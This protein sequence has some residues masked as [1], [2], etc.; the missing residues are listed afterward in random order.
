[1]VCDFLHRKKTINFPMVQ[2]KMVLKFVPN[3]IFYYGPTITIFILKNIGFT[4]RKMRRF[5]H[6]FCVTAIL[7]CSST[8]LFPG[9][10]ETV[11]SF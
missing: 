3:V 2:Q 8:N 1:M 11:F 7:N 9:I 4:H 6:I 5:S 10:V